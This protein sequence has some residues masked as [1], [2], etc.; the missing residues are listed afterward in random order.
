[1]ATVA[2]SPLLSIRG[3]VAGYGRV[4]VLHGL[5]LDVRPGEF[6]GVIGHNGAGKSTLLKVIA[7]LIRPTRGSVEMPGAGGGRRERIAL[8]PQGLAVFPRMSV[9]ENLDIPRVASRDES[10]LMPREAVLDLFPALRE[11]GRQAAGTLSGG[12]QR[13]VAIG[14][15]LRLAPRLLLLDEPSLGLA[16]KVAARIV[17]AVDQVRRQLGSTVVVV[18]QNLEVL[19]RRAERLVALRQ[20]VLAW[21]GDPGAVRDV[22]ALWEY[23]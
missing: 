13:M 22:R 20:G 18:E 5:D 8:V 10:R 14:M 23:F 2:A 7:G 16:P 12:E 9:D 17:E 21:E 6:L 3:L 15:A 19:L 11:R 1:M 4:E